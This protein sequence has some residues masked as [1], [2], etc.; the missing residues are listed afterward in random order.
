MAEDRAVNWEWKTGREETHLW[1]QT[2]EGAAKNRQRKQPFETGTQPEASLSS[3]ANKELWKPPNHVFLLLPHVFLEHPP[4][5]TAP[6]AP[7]AET[8]TGFL[9]PNTANSPQGRNGDQRCHA[10]P[11]LFLLLLTPV[12]LEFTLLLAKYPTAEQK[13]EK[14]YFS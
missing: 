1:Q 12:T 6:A 3:A 10:V 9:A 4:A 5:S 8:T 2:G 7:A 13:L 11:L 14:K